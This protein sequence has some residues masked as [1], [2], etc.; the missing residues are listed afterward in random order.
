MQ[1]QQLFLGIGIIMKGGTIHP[2][3]VVAGYSL[4]LCPMEVINEDESHR[5]VIRTLESPGFS[6][7]EVSRE[8]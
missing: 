4:P 7:G 2:R 6:R 1:R 3:P 8:L 5:E